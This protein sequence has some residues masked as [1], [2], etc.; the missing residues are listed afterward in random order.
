M[1][2][3]N[4]KFTQQIFISQKTKNCK[5]RKDDFYKSSRVTNFALSSCTLRL[6]DFLEDNIK[7]IKTLVF[8][9]SAARIVTSVITTTAA[10]TI[11]V[12]V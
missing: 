5:E 8:L 3:S 2:I 4:Y 11:T 10:I 1:P 12:I 6:K 7:R 9:I